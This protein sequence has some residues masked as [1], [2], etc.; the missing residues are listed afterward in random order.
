MRCSE[1][2]R[3]VVVAIHASRGPSRWVVRP[4][5]THWNDTSIVMVVAGYIFAIIGCIV[6]L[7]GEVLML[8]LAYRRG[9][10]WLLAC[11]LLAPLCWLALLPVGFKS[12]R[13]PFAL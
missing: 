9:F 13:R 4:L 10:G 11:L 8:R 3:P 2:W 1:R 6:C 5:H 7:I 12:T